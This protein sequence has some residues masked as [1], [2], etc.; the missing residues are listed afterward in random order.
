MIEL[1][2]TYRNLLISVTV[3]PG[4][5]PNPEILQLL[6]AYGVAS[7]DTSSGGTWLWEDHRLLHSPSPEQYAYKID[8][9]KYYYI[10]PTAIPGADLITIGSEV[11]T[12]PEA[13]G[14]DILIYDTLL[15][16]LIAHFQFE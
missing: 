1:P 13:Q 8:P 6:E 3:H 7:A 9:G 11:Y 15:N 4:S 2:K 12:T 16:K 10:R 5:S 14:T